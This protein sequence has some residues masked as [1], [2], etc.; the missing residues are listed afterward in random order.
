MSNA[1]SEKAHPSSIYTPIFLN[2]YCLNQYIPALALVTSYLYS[3]TLI[4]YSNEVK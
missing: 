3:V 2:K 4:L 1:Y